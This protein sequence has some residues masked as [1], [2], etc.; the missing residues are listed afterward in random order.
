MPLMDLDIASVD[1]S[2]SEARNFYNRVSKYYDTLAA[3]EKKFI[4]T[5][6]ELL[7]VKPGEHILEIGYGTGYAIVNIARRTGTDGHV[8]G[9]DISSGMTQ[10]ALERIG[11]HNVA[12]RV[13]LTVDDASHLPYQDRCMDGIFLSFTLELFHTEE[14]PQVLAEC[15]RVLKKDGRICIV[16][17]AKNQPMSLIGQAYEWLHDKFPKILDCRPIPVRTLL[18]DANF[19]IRNHLDD[20]MWG[21][22]VS[23]T[24]ADK[25]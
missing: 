22:P 11:K 8:Y 12:D 7:G 25:S 10:V 17:L 23:I 4:K 19:H 18:Q 13:S 2:K 20:A 3:S 6:I 21:I 1:R 16:S 15:L 14:L 5:G 24:L 9:I